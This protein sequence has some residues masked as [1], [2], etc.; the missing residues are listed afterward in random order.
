LAGNV[1][2]DKGSV[3]GELRLTSLMPLDNTNFFQ[4]DLSLVDWL[5]QFTKNDEER[6]EEF[7][8]GFLGRMLFW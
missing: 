3:A 2:A 6:H 8:R 4:E 1:E 7:V 5:R